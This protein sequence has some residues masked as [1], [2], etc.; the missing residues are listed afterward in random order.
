MDVEIESE[1]V[2]YNDE[3]RRGS[4][5]FKKEDKLCGSNM[6]FSKQWR[7]VRRNTEIHLFLWISERVSKGGKKVLEDYKIEN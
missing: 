2:T 5:W 6:L 4:N 3:Y 1:R 7:N